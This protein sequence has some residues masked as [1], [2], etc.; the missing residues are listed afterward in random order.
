MTRKR[1]QGTEIHNW[2]KRQRMVSGRMQGTKNHRMK[3]KN[4]NND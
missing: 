3:D 4:E 1:M 2:K